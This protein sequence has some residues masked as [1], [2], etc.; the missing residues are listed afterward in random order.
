M[1]PAHFDALHQRHAGT[2]SQAR[3]LFV[4]DCSPAPI[5][6]TACRSASSPSTP[7]TACSPATCSS[8]IPAGGAGGTAP[9]FTVI[10]APSFKADPARHGTRSDV[11]IA[12]ELRQRL[13]LIG[14]TSYAGEIK[15]SIF[16]V[17][18]YLLPL[19]GVLPMHCSANVGP[20]ATS[21]LFFGLSGTGKTTLSSDPERAADRRRRARLERSRRVQLRRRLLREDDRLSAEAEPQIYATTRRFGTVLE[22]VVVDPATRAARSR[23]RP[24]HG[25][26]ARP[27]IRCRSST[28]RCRRARAAIRRTSSC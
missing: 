16:T 12:R 27:R 10:D 1:S 15:K 25:E 23:R 20:A 6:G 4:Q 5:P 19:S 17:L 28:T 8:P 7:G 26:H 21:A 11:V 24:L 2:H 9:A 14:G 22:N 3:E 13:V 18:N